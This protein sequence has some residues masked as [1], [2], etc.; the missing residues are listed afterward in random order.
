M[1]SFH[2]AKR[3]LII[4]NFQFFK[5]MVTPSQ[6]GVVQHLVYFLLMSGFARNVVKL[7][8]VSHKQNQLLVLVVSL[9][10]PL[11]LA[12]AQ[13]TLYPTSTGPP[14][15]DGP[16]GG[17]AVF[18]AVPGWAA[19]TNAGEITGCSPGQARGGGQGKGSLGFSP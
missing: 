3:Q 2:L 10:V 1:F 5:W 8:L 15:S 13:H 9:P 18:Q 14:A 12:A 17:W 4:F 7:L 6:G 19:W 16:T 11:I